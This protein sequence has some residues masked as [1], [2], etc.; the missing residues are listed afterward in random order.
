MK[1][2]MSSLVVDLDD[3]GS[4]AT[5]MD[6]LQKHSLMKARARLDTL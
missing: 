4:K 5:L 2:Y 3:S 6:A 1:F